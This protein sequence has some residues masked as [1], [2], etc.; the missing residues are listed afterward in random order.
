MLRPAYTPG[1]RPLI[2]ITNDDGIRSPGLKAVA[3]ALLD[4]GDVLIA[5]PHEQ[6]TSMGRGRPR[7]DV[8]GAITRIDLELNGQPHPAYAVLG[9]PAQCV[10]H[11][12]AEIL[13]HLG[14]TASL[15]VSGINYG[16]NVGFSLTA[17]GTAG[18]AYE[19]AAFGLPALAVSVETP[20]ALHH[21][22]T[23]GALDWEAAGHF[24][25]RFAAKVL[26]DG[27]PEAVAFLNVNV[28]AA[29]DARTP[30]RFTVNTRH[31]YYTVVEQPERDFDQP[32]RLLEGKHT[33]VAALEQGSDARALHEGLVS[34]TPIGFNLTADVD[35]RGW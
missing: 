27:L 17:S 12:V 3:E 11:A 2:L 13:P 6:Q 24:A 32:Y 28:P 1:V 4:L 31:N 30:V 10:G 18:A 33:D 15:C 19:A 9:S 21:G 22:A 26:R 23:Y 29:A 14:R 25:R 34:V 20:M 8:A 5:A 7:S 35:L 16:E